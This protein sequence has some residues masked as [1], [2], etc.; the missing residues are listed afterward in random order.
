MITILQVLKAF[1]QHRQD[2]IVDASLRFYE[3]N[4]PDTLHK[5][6]IVFVS[7]IESLTCSSH[8]QI[9]ALM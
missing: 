9:I 1:Y 2:Q 7:D 3:W 4:L 6:W 8:Y 5:S